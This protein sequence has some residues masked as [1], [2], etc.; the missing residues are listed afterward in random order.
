[1]SFLI[2]LFGLSCQPFISLILN[3][4]LSVR[5]FA[6][7]EYYFSLVTVI[8]IAVSI[9]LGGAAITGIFPYALGFHMQPGLSN[10]TK[11]CVAS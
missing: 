4:A 1:M 9:L 10:L 7:S 6:E 8:A 2:L 3:N 5:V 11:K